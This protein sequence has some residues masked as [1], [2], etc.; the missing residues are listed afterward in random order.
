MS[1][2]IEGSTRM[3]L[4]NTE[5]ELHARQVIFVLP[6]TI[7]EPKEASVDFRLYCIVFDYDFITSSP[8][9]H[10]L[11]IDNTIRQPPIL[12]LDD[13]DFLF[14]EQLFS[15]I[16][17]HYYRSEVPNKN[18]VIAYL[19]SALISEINRLFM[20]RSETRKVSSSENITNSFLTLLH[21][22]NRI[23]RLFVCLITRQ[24][25]NQDL[26]YSYIIRQ[27]NKFMDQLNNKVAA[28][29]LIFALMGILTFEA[30]V[31]IGTSDTPHRDAL[32]DL[33][34]KA[35]GTSDKGL[36]LPRVALENENNPSRSKNMWKVCMCSIQQQMQLQHL[37]RIL[38]TD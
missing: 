3:K 22:S 35:D 9:L 34:Q 4:N 10:S 8:L 11:Y 33:K 7:V 26:G 5:Q 20:S 21:K 32:F 37:V 2:C 30:Q 6:N 14:A 27:L 13:E 31:T 17:Q 19:L 12:G 23:E 38:T 24:I 16:N 15:L 29:M 28:L 36:L 18:E 25:I 1:L